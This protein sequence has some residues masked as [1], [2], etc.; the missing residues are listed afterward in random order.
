MFQISLLMALENIE[1]GKVSE[2]E[3]LSLVNT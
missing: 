1:K 2:D 3:K